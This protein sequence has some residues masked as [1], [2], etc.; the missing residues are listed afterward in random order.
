MTNN[1]TDTN[2]KVNP[3]LVTRLSS[4]HEKVT[5]VGEKNKDKKEKKVKPA[6]KFKM[7]V[8]QKENRLIK[9]LEHGIIPPAFDES[10]WKKKPK[11]DIYFHRKGERISILE[12]D[13]KRKVCAEITMSRFRTRLMKMFEDLSDAPGDT[14]K[15]GVSSVFLKNLVDRLLCSGREL[16]QWPKPIGFKS[17]T[18][19]VFK[20]LDFDPP[21][22]ATIDQFPT[23]AIN[24][25]SI[26]TNQDAFCAR[27]GSLYDEAAS[28][29]QVIVLWGDGD[30]GK[31][32]VLN[33]L[34]ELVGGEIATANVT[35][36]V[37]DT[38]GMVDLK[39]KRLWI[40]D[41]ITP[42]FFTHPQFKR[43][44]G[45]S[46]VTIN[47]KYVNN[48]D[49]YLKGILFCAMNSQPYFKDDSGIRNRIIICKTRPIPA[50]KRID[51]NEAM[52]RMR[53]ELPYFI[54]YCK[55]KMST[56]GARTIVQDACPYMQIVEEQE[57]EYKVAFDQ[58]FELAPELDGGAL[59]IYSGGE[60]ILAEDTL[61]AAEYVRTR[62]EIFSNY[63]QLQA[64]KHAVRVFNTYVKKR[65]DVDALFKSQKLSGNRVL[66]V[67]AGLK[68]RKY[69]YV[70]V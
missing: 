64:C 52:K 37:F 1:K 47:Q 36:H 25:D 15:Y 60:R 5:E 34:R 13:T 9:L 50:E 66:K 35:E 26:T 32:T 48:Y 22:D 67:V 19:Y 3:V 6:P 23:I 42:G 41:E 58:F 28:R 27:V 20:R 65:L 29:K 69:P 46:P 56:S 43:L 7:T 11:W 10:F 8:D 45:D 2:N 40:G 61:T 68:L 44:T 51:G 4:A 62:N 39:D 53:A 33:L 24:L 70:Q 12:V 63:Y 14:A 18:D 16:E 54:A 17:D 49:V 31:S 30:S 57:M 21:E 55:K 59:A 38:H